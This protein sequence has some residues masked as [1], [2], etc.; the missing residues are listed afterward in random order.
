MTINQFRQLAAYKYR[1]TVFPA[2]ETAI[3]DYL[4]KFGA[5]FR[6]GA[7]ESVNNRGGSSCTYNVIIDNVA[8]PLTGDPGAPAFK[9]TL[10]AGD[11]N[12]LALA[13]F[14]AS[15]DRDT[16]LAQRIVVIDDPMTSL[17]ENR[18]LT[19]VQEMHRLTGKVAQV[20]VL[21]HSRPF[22]CAMWKKSDRLPRAAIKVIRDRDGSD[23]VAWNVQQD[24][25]TDHD[26]RHAKVVAYIASNNAADEREVA[27]SLRPILESFMRVGY[28]EDFPPDSLLGHFH[29]LC[30]QRI[31]QSNQ[32]LSAAD[33][34]E[35][36]DLIDYANRFHHDNP[37]WQTEVINDQ[38]LHHFCQRTLAFT[39]R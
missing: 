31:G 13:F 21:S 18:S 26:K 36:K 24:S 14:F 10:S 7:V 32:I 33:A 8:V 17:D 3:N 15:L 34:A 19:T 38:E 11:R 39:R 9:N 23:L 4:R 1:A 25:I 27:E 30:L 16:R 20:V 35:L 2:Y 28:P 5:G 6:L 22:L 12:T 29:N 37:T